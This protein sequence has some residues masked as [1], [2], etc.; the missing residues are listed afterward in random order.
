MTA[1]L[2]PIDALR[3]QS[4]ADPLERQVTF[5]DLQA[6]PL[7]F[8]TSMPRDP[9]AAQVDSLEFKYHEGELFKN[10]KAAAQAVHAE[11]LK[12]VAAAH[13]AP[14]EMLPKT[15][16]KFLAAVDRSALPALGLQIAEDW[17]FPHSAS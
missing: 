11:Q 1:V 16:E 5:D 3:Y 9:V 12:E 13:L 8:Q 4:R 17:N 10:A 6:R 7:G 15:T 14:P 2:S